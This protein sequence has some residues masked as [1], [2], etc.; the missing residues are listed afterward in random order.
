MPGIESENDSKVRE[1]QLSSKAAVSPETG[2]PV[3]IQA[4]LWPGGRD[5]NESENP[6]VGVRYN[7]TQ[8]NLW[9]VLFGVYCCIPVGKFIFVGS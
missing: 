4:T 2:D 6:A 3:E 1:Q 8:P 7:P 5:P 9:S